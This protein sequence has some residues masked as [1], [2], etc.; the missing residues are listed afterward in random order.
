MDNPFERYHC[1]IALPGFGEWGQELLRSARVLVIGAGGLGCPATQY[2]TAAGIGTIGMADDDTISVKNLHRQ[3]LFNPDDTGKKK[4]DILCKR[5]HAQ[6]PSIRIIPYDLRVTSDNV[7]EL[8]SGYDLIM[9]GADN[10]ETKC[11]INDACVLAGKPLIY[12]AIYQYEG[13]VAVWNVRG[14]AGTYSP[15]Y[16]D[17]FPDVENA[18]VPNC[19]DGGVLPTLAGIVG[20]MQANEA[21]K[22]FIHDKNLLTGKLW[23]MNVQSGETRIIQ[24]GKITHTKITTLTPSVPV[25]TY[26]EL[27]GGMYELIDVRT[28]E[29]NH[30]F[31]IGGKNIPLIKLEEQIS[32]VDS[33]KTVVFYCARGERSERAVNI[34]K[35]YFPGGKAYSLKGGIENLKRVLL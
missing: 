21:I 13:Q 2:L 12:G 27:E 33:S 1:Q 29:E 24:L 23:M 20:C 6:N 7:M 22:Y 28:E 30:Y 4:V 16:H 31:N 10:F 18:Q 5:L 25:I 15:N 3:V 8:I 26:S 17:V 11:L 32:F 19:A 34:F 14:S 9:E 35:K